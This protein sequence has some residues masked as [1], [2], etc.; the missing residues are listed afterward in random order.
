MKATTYTKKAAGGWRH[1]DDE[2][3]IIICMH[4]Q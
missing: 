4:T 2:H 3:L 1:G